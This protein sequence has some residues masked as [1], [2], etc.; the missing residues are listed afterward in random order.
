MSVNVSPRPLLI[1]TGTPFVSEPVP[2][3]NKGDEWL[4]IR[5]ASEYL[6]VS[7]QTIFR[8]MR[9]G[10]LSFFKF[11]NAT[12]FRRSNL[13]MLAEKVTSDSEG[14]LAATRCGLC[15]NA[16]MIEGVI[17]STGRI[18]FQP[19]RTKFLVLMDSWTKVRAMTCPACGHIQLFADTEKLAKLLPEE[20]KS[21]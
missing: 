5:E 10:K 6:K 13:D 15:G 21:G 12:R 1:A 20:D 14:E 7:E 19:A 8:W 4:T 11:G 2:S 9:T 18:Y 16:Q 17:R 3:A